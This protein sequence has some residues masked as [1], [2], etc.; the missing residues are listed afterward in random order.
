MEHAKEFLEFYLREGYAEKY[1]LNIFNVRADQLDEEMLALMVRCGIKTL[2][3]GVESADPEVFR[4]VGKN[5]TLDEIRKG[6][7]TIQHAGIVPWLNMIVGLPL[8]TPERNRN[9]IE[10]VK[11]IP[12]PKIVHWFQYAPFRRTK[13][14]GFMVAARAIY[15]GY[16]PQPYGKR[17]DE[18][19]WFPDFGTRDFTAQQRGL[20]QLEAF[21]E[22]R[23]PIL[24]NSMPKVTD[25]CLNNGM[26]NLLA[27]WI[28]D[29][30]IK[31]YIENSL[32]DKQKKGQL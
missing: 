29:A 17:Y 16:I 6:I 23:A 12:D 31:E 26:H 4:Y 22:T 11:S 25:L 7:E 28:R 30:P 32:K 24:Y 9:S 27:D 13:A 1:A 2:P 20:A 8:D 10:W 21:L 15:D 19:P 5:E 3:I 14:Y 18:L